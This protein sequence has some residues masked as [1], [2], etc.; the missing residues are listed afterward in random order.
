[1]VMARKLH[2]HAPHI[3]LLYLVGITF[4]TDKSAYYVDVSYLK[5]F[6]DVSLVAGYAWGAAALSNLYMKLSNA[7][8][9]NMKHMSGYLSLLQV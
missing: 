1:M 6:R 2:E 8:H 7:S 4:F 5:Y 3:Y 9:Y